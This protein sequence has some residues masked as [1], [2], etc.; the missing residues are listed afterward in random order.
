MKIITLRVKKR[1]TFFEKT[2][3][4]IGAKNATPLFFLTRFGIHTF[5]LSFPIDVIV[6]DDQNTVVIQKEQLQPNRI[7]FW[8]PVYSRVLELPVG[9]I[10]KYHIQ[11]GMTIHIAEEKKYTSN[12]NLHSER[13]QYVFSKFVKDE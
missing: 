6:L 12:N 9:F 13:I 11:K 7:F 3:G 8:N 4:L 10:K 1:K 2:K 5:F